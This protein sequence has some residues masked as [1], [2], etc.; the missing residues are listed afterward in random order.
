MKLIKSSILFLFFIFT[1]ISPVSAEVLVAPSF[2]SGTAVLSDHGITPT[3]TWSITQTGNTYS[4]LYTFSDAAPLLNAI[5][6]VGSAVTASEIQNAN[7]AFVGP[8][9][10]TRGTDFKQGLPG[11]IFG[12]AFEGV[13]NTT[14]TYSFTSTQAPTWGNFYGT[15][16]AGGCQ[17]NGPCPV[18]DF[19]FNSQFSNTPLEGQSSYNGWV[20]V[21]G[22]LAAPEPSAWLILGSNLLILSL[23]V[24]FKKRRNEI[25][26]TRV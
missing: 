16:I 21:P 20:P 1:A 26:R 7:H 3:L 15:S 6:Q 19:A 4:Y 25:C 24:A 13:R 9:T 12:I 23:L 18:F 5:F 11:P 14:I 8:Q 2:F 10:F 17:I 22:S